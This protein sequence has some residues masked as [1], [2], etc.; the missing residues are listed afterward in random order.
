MSD[1]IHQVRKVIKR[2]GRTVPFNPTKLNKLA[3]FATD[4][5][6]VSWSEIALSAINKLYDGCTVHDITKA[7]IDAC[8]DK[9][10]EDHVKIAGRLFTARLRKDVFPDTKGNPPPL[11]QF[12]RD[13]YDQ[14]L[15]IPFH[16]YY[17]EEEIDLIDSW[18]QHDK[19]FALSFSQINQLVEKYLLRSLTDNRIY[20][21][22][23]FM[24]A[25]LAMAVYATHSK[26]TRMKYI[27]DYL[28]SCNK[29]FLNLPSPNL[30]NIGT[31]KKTATS[32]CLYKSGDT[33]KSISA[34]NHIS[35][36]M[37]VAGAGLGLT[38]HVR[39][40]GDPVKKGTIKHQGKIPYYKA[41]QGIVK[42]NKQG[43]YSSDTEVLTDK[44]F[45]PF[46]EVT[47]T[48]KIAQIKDDLELEY[49]LPTRIIKYKHTGDMYQFKS[50]FVDVLVTPDHRMIYSDKDTVKLKEVRADSFAPIDDT[51]FFTSIKNDYDEDLDN[52][53]IEQLSITTAFNIVYHFNKEDFS[54]KGRS[55][56]YNGSIDYIKNIVNSIDFENTD[57][58]DDIEHALTPELH[59]TQYNEDL[60]YLLLRSN[61]KE[62][63]E[64]QP[65]MIHGAIASVLNHISFENEF[66][67]LLKRIIPF[68]SKKYKVTEYAFVIYDG[69]TVD[70]KDVTVTKVEYDDYV[71]CVEVPSNVIVVRRND[72][73]LVC[74]NSR[75]GALTVYTPAL[76]P[77]IE[78]IIRARNPATVETV[79]VDDIDQAVAY[80][81]YLVH[82][83]S[84]D[85]SWMLV[86]Y[87][88]A[89]KL[90][91]L[92]FCSRDKLPEFIEEYN[93][94]KDDES[95]P[96]S[97][98]SARS[99]LILMRSQSHETGRVYGGNFTNINTHTPF[100]EPIYS[101]NLCTEITLPTAEFDSVLD[102][103]D[104]LSSEYLYLLLEGDTQE[105]VIKDV[106]EARSYYKKVINREPFTYN[107]KAVVYAKYK[108]EIALCNIA[109]IN[110]Q[111]DM[112]EED[113]YKACLAALHTID[114]VIDNS[115]FPFPNVAYSAKARRSAGVGMSNLAYV[116]ASKH[117]YYSSLEGQK[118]AFYLAERH[119]YMLLKASM[120]IAKEAG[121]ETEWMYKTK[122]KD[123]WL[124]I[125]TGITETLSYLTSNFELTYDWKAVRAELKAGNLPRHSVLVAHMPC[126]SSSIILNSTNGLYPIRRPVIVKKSGNVTS[127]V[128]IVPE[129]EKLKYYYENAYDIPFEEL[130]KFYAC[131]QVWTDQAISADFYYSQELDLEG[132]PIP[133]STGSLLNQAIV[134]SELGLKTFYYT[135]TKSDLNEQEANRGCSSGACDV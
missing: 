130:A 133:I 4:T 48:T 85:E 20:E 119:Y 131:I 98:I 27:E 55:Y 103:Y 13:M 1:S 37:T 58:L 111:P 124:P 69:N 54:R 52:P 101:S 70:T 117:L 86:S 15:Y 40:L 120:Q 135:N 71:Y 51:V 12:L 82:L 104:P 31:N 14:G 53:L 41:A 25:R 6:K 65:E 66:I 19:D 29:D 28:Y 95:I 125:D 30:S 34:A 114:Y 92:M 88:Y 129:Y 16:D 134:S 9:A 38:M 122:W 113:Y 56:T 107:G 23:Q 32:C 50:D 21:V 46:S 17:S 100:L 18:L 47:E 57:I 78:T 61:P 39:S 76:D 121:T 72:S 22:P 81:D 96:K 109:A 35:D 2:S 127:N 49:V 64:F 93:R 74:G 80:N 73:T 79:K 105:T 5:T 36:N 116:M 44:G 89:P 102:L 33:V 90:W 126:E 97:F 77:E 94:V 132:K 99:L 24:Y 112:T 8:L 43:C 106:K 45:I 10:T 87:Y 62:L 115:E 128:Q 42:S 110:L 83:A 108:N 26:E 91:E 75:G 60:L 11:K 59:S 3:S 68:T 123:G 7:L 67:D 118:Y 84:K 63:I